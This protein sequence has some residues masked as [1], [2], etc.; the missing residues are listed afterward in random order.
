[1]GRA[2]EEATLCAL[3]E[4]L[5]NSAAIDEVEP[6]VTRFREASKEKL[7][8]LGIAES[9]ELHSLCFTARLYEV[10]CIRI[11]FFG[12]PSPCL[13]VEFHQGRYNLS[14]GDW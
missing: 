11:T 2:R 1:M 14:I 4:A 8:G 6:L 7:F 9:A 3:I 13:G 10:L 12:T 5:F